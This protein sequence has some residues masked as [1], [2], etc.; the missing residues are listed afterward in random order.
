VPSASSWL[1]IA[2]PCTGT[3]PEAVRASGG[4]ASGRAGWVIRARLS[5]RRAPRTAVAGQSWA[6]GGCPAAV[7][8]RCAL[9]ARSRWTFVEVSARARVARVALVWGG[10]PA[11]SCRSGRA[12]A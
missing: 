8:I 9:V 3:G 4:V 1:T 6:A 5:G 7:S 11:A 12:A 2:T 10:V